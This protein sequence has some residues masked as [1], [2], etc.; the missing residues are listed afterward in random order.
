MSWTLPASPFPPTRNAAIR[1][2]LFATLLAL[3]LTAAG[4]IR[5][6]A[7]AHAPGPSVD[8]QDIIITIAAGTDFKSIRN[9][10]LDHRVITHGHYFDAL[11]RLLGVT[12]KIKAG[13][14]RFSPDRTPLTI[15]EKLVS[16]DIFL[17]PLT[18]PE[19][20]TIAQI[21]AQL[22]AAGRGHADRFLA[23]AKDRNFIKSLDLGEVASLEGYLFPD[24]YHLQGSQDEAAILRMMTLRMTSVLSTA[25]ESE[26]TTAQNRLTEFPE[27]ERLGVRLTTHQI[28]TLAS[29]VEKEAAR[30]EERV[31]VAAVLLNRLRKGIRLQA[32]PTVIYGIANFSGNLT[33]VDLRTDTPY[34]TYR[35]KG[36][37]P[38]PITN[39]G[40]Q[41]I[42]AV[43]LPPELLRERF[44]DLDWQDRNRYLYFVSRND[45][46]H[47]FS[48]TLAAHN[49]AVA[50]YQ[51]KRQGGDKR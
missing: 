33:R 47:H 17:W 46:T 10:L 43:L 2:I 39:P 50:R 13:D 32:D 5:L 38:G 44:P 19:G 45:G 24:T 36:L 35:I 34:N 16:G 22:E 3:G 1:L 49:Q 40:R 28:L 42:E 11:A 29:I 41:A 30:P 8:N 6:W 23:L 27:V 21:A 48:K 25:Y 12:Q 37:P 7:Y 26:T 18:I 4:I 20:L 15:L 9:T 14:Y 31:M 51:K